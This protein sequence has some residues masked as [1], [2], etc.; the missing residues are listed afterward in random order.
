MTEQEIAIQKEI[1]RE[2]IEKAKT[3]MEILGS[4]RGPS[5]K[6]RGFTKPTKVKTSRMKTFYMKKDRQS[7]KDFQSGKVSVA[8]MMALQKQGK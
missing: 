4:H 1:E 5:T 6:A 8:E 2:A 3:R 7:W